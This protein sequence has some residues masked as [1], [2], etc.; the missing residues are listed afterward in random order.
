M[1]AFELLCT[2]YSCTFVSFVKRIKDTNINVLILEETF[3]IYNIQIKLH[4][5]FVTKFLR[6]YIAT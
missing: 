5:Y 1:N 6:I 4:E 2:K 3:Q